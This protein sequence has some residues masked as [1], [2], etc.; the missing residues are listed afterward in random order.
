[1]EGNVEAGFVGLGAMG[2]PIAKNLLAGGHQLAVWN[3]T[4]ARADALAGAGARV[5]GTPAEAA[6]AGLVVSMV[7][8]DAALDAVASGADGL[9]A[10][11]PRGGVHVSMSTV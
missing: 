9:V 5:A 7:A 8:D 6:R 1:M 3:R 10:G 4:R 2:T 11:L